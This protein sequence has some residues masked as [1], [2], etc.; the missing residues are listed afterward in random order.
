MKIRQTRIGF[1]CAGM[2]LTFLDTLGSRAMRRKRGSAPVFAKRLFA[3][4]MTSLIAA[5]LLPTFAQAQ[6]AGGLAD[7]QRQLVSLYPTA[8]ATADGMDL[9]TAG[10]VLVLQKDNLQMCK[11]DQP[12]PSANFYK[13][14]VITQGGLGG[15]F[16]AMNALNRL[17]NAGGGAP[18]ADNREFVAGEKFFVTRISTGPDGVTFA[19]MSDPIKDQR[20]KG[21]LKF[22][23][24]RGTVPSPG[25][26]AAMVAEV[27]K[28]DAPAESTEQN[29]S[30]A[31][32]APTKTI[33]LGQTR[34]EVIAMFG[35][36]AKVVQV[37]TK[38]IDFFADMKVTFV[39]NKVANVE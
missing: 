27:I 1:C 38:E 28:I 10:A 35:V 19:F 13:N 9:V 3:I 8:K 23:F 7:I 12:M 34:D 32:A 33:A 4:S 11:V 16:K 17:G 18:P 15:L 39:K 21:N 5:L 20:Y 29:P 36:P 14:G 22:P 26:V 31:G 24:P 6:G 2:H 30:P 37:G 25:D